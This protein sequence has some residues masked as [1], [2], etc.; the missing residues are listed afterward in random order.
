MGFTTESMPVQLGTVTNQ[1]NQ[2]DLPTKEFVGYDPKGTTSITGSP[3]ANKPKEVPQAPTEPAAAPVPEVPKDEDSITLSPKIS[4]IARKEQALRAAQ[5]AQ[6]EKERTFA[7]KMADAE[8]Y[9]VLTEKL[10]NKDYSAAEELGLSYEEYVKHE[11]NKE[12]SKDPSQERLKKVEEELASVKKQ[13]EED[14]VKEYQANQALWKKEIVRVV[15]ENPEFSTIKKK[16]AEDLVLQ[17][18][19]DSFE[20]DNIELTVEQAS[21]DIEEALKAKAKEWASLL[22]AEENVVPEA[23]VLGAPKTKVSTITQNMTVSSTQTKPKPFHL[24]SESEQIQEAIRRV[25]AAKLQR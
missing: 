2:F 18:I 10:K 11:L 13:R 5:K 9:R 20:E 15:S 16:G 7:E 17:H 22:E 21:K 24:M 6:S 19:N 23:K 1:P 14:A 4:A 3:L 25:Q 8:K 12:T